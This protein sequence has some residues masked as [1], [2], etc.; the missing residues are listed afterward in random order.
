M[1]I[2][3]ETV[4]MMMMDIT[5]VYPFWW[6]S[7]PDTF[8]QDLMVTQL[9]K[10]CSFW[11]STELENDIIGYILNKYEQWMHTHFASICVW[12]W[13]WVLNEAIG[14]LMKQFVSYPHSLCCVAFFVIEYWLISVSFLQDYFCATGSIMWW[15]IGHRLMWKSQVRWI[16][17]P[18][19]QAIGCLLCVLLSRL[20]TMRPYILYIY[21]LNE[22][23]MHAWWLACPGYSYKFTSKSPWGQDM[24][25]WWIQPIPRIMHTVHTWLW[26]GG[27]LSTKMLSYQ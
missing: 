1:Q 4:D 17:H 3:S 6:N 21:K 5:N 24:Y 25:C 12:I 8:F 16:S 22:G 10:V 15:T 14:F 23:R 18:H 2:W 13:H 19:W 26:S 9:N 7:L 11:V 20:T 27:H